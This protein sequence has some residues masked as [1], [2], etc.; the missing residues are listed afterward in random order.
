MCLTLSSYCVSSSI[1]PFVAGNM[2]VDGVVFSC[3]VAH[4]QERDNLIMLAASYFVRVSI[5]V[6]SIG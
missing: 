4:T 5:H 3:G 1:D 6:D 2:H